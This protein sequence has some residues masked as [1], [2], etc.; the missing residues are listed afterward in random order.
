MKNKP[1]R[2]IAVITFIIGACKLSSGVDKGINFQVIPKE[3]QLVEAR[4]LLSNFPVSFSALDLDYVALAAAEKQLKRYK[5]IFA[6]YPKLGLTGALLLTQLQQYSLFDEG[7]QYELEMQTTFSAF[8][9][10]G[11]KLVIDEED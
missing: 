6:K 3:K 4:V 9:V 5:S 11:L 2:D 10:N 8:K 7:G 1:K